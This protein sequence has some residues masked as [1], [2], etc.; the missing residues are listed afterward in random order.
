MRPAFARLSA[1]TGI[2]YRSNFTSPK[3]SGISRALSLILPGIVLAALLVVI[4]HSAFGFGSSHSSFIEEWVYD[5]VTMST[6]LAT[7]WRAATRREE[8][9][10]WALLG[11]GLLGWALGDLYWTVLLRDMANPPFPSGSDA[12]YLV[13][14]VL[15]LAGMVAYVRTRVG[16]MSAIVWTDVAMGALCVT[17]IGS[18]LLLDYVLANTT[19]SSNIALGEFGNWGEFGRIAVNVEAVY[20]DLEPGYEPAGIVEQFRRMAELEGRAR[21]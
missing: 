8:R 6:A 3:T 16:R 20:R 12:L 9:L 1:W 10:A 18:S 2:R 5:F 14:Y 17:T 7:L 13:G 21:P 11:A 19:G 15:I 4:A